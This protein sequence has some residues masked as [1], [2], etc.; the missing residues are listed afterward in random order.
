[1][2]DQE[3]NKSLEDLVA[4]IVNSMMTKGLLPKLTP[5]GHKDLINE[6]STT[7]A[8]SGELYP[9]DLNNDEA[10]KTIGLACVACL[11]NKA[12]PNAQLDYKLL[13][14]DENTV[15]PKDLKNLVKTI[16]KE[17]LKLTPEKM[18]KLS[19]DEEEKLIDHAADK[20]I[21]K[22][23]VNKKDKK[24]LFENKPMM[25]MLAGCL[26]VLSL[27]RR[28]FYGVDTSKPGEEFIAQQSQPFGEQMGIQDLATFGT[29]FAGELGSSNPGQ[30]DPAGIH[31]S[32]AMNALADGVTS[33]FERHLE[34]E[35]IIP[36]AAPPKTPFS[37]RPKGPT[38]L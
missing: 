16:L 36:S 8:N 11:F 35:N 30:P 31:W 6:V 18:R 24:A 22:K 38:E 7:L 12:H 27:Q 9:A 37:M 17:M 34:E 10:K 1:M 14:K 29:S 19:K 13:F 26:D 15:D 5:E 3:F 28:A 33:E 20:V 21:E 2:G 32:A 4:R 25:E 23:V